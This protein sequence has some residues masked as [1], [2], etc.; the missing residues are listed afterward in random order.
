MKMQ[1]MVDSGKITQEEADEKI[2]Y[3]MSGKGKR[4]WKKQNYNNVFSINIIVITVSINQ[5][6]LDF[7]IA[8]EKIVFSNFDYF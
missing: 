4:G 6:P 8:I 2:E 7:S 3:M 5:K 1:S